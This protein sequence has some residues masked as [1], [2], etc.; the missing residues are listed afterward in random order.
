M[1]P[2][3][4]ECDVVLPPGASQESWNP[5]TVIIREMGLKANGKPRN[6]P[7]RTIFLEAAAEAVRQYLF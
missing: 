4:R 6:L 1:H 5:C 7:G 2:G 3:N